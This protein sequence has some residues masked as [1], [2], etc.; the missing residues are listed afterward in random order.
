MEKA[1]QIDGYAQLMD[2]TVKGNCQLSVAISVVVFHVM[3]MV[4]GLKP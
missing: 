1:V 4:F 2:L 3:D